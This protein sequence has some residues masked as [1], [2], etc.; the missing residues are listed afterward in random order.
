MNNTALIAVI[1]V[2]VTVAVLYALGCYHHRQQQRDRVIERQE[3]DRLERVSQ[4]LHS[5]RMAQAE[6]AQAALI[7]RVDM[8]HDLLTQV[9]AQADRAEA[10]KVEV[11]DIVKAL[12]TNFGAIESRLVNIETG[13]GWTKRP[14]GM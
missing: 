10:A 12:D 2:C 8:V 13:L 11:A 7:T 9:T 14:E 1:I 5:E 4:R 6:R 3:D